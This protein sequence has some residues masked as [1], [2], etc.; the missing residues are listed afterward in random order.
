M[1]N[2]VIAIG[3]DAADPTILEKW[4]SQ[5]H[6]KNLNRLRQQGAYGRLLNNDSYRAETPWTT[7]LTGTLPEKT[8]YW[9]PVKYD[10]S[11]YQVKET[12]AYSF[13]EYPP[14]YA[15]G[16]DYKVAV[17]DM[18]QSALSEEAN[19]PQVL[20]W[21]AH[22]PQVPSQSRPESLFKELVKKHGAH[23]V[24]NKDY[25]DC[26]D[27]NALRYLQKSLEVGIARR[28][29][30]C[31]DLLERDDWNLFLTI[32][33]E[34]HSAGHYL[35]HMSQDHPIHKLG[36][37][38]APDALLEIHEA[39]D[40]AIGEIINKASANANILI[41]AAHGMDSNV[42]DLPSML[43]LPEFLYRWNFPGKYGVAYTQSGSRLQPPKT[44]FKK[45]GWIG[46]VWDLKYES[47]PLKSWLR[48]NTPSKLYN[49]L[50]QFLPKSKS[51]KLV[52]PYQQREQSDSL[53]WQP[54]NWYKPLWPEMKAFALP[55]YS[56]G[57]VRINLQNR[58]AYGI[59]SPDDYEAT[60][61]ELCHHL[62]RLVDARTGK[63]MVS[64]IIRTRKSATDQDPKLPDAD[65]IVLWQE[66][67]ATDV[68][69]SPDFGRIGP[70]PYHRTG[71][72]RA[73]GFLLAK[74][75]DFAPNS[76]LPSDIK[77]L[78][79]APTI[80]ELLDAPVPEYFDGK[81]LVKRFT[82]SPIS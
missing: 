25:A 58:E 30:I 36:D 26:R 24:L 14:F 75:P 81:P 31:Q 78:D 22:S 1:K 70:V 27:A 61:N 16:Q 82:P 23:P 50:E 21:G 17:F 47:N 4:M 60:C 54:A 43:F 32:F 57:Y 33:G 35:W 10:A 44:T 45:R 52:S 48:Q 28:S 19:G 8:G 65:L 67:Y 39:I 12:G 64:E 42:M 79:L 2:P 49:R 5:G 11:S 68:I 59:V 40:R 74:G 6:L 29:A 34:T 80:L 9:G 72:H 66:D 3:L 51:D 15:L 71:S 63:P 18:P 38:S 46:E 37:S 56:E 62:A 20:A 7:F 76:T 13:A 77:A 41:F 73:E 53:F 55:S 69:D